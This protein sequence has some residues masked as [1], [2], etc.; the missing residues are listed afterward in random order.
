MHLCITIGGFPVHPNLNGQSKPLKA[1]RPH[2]A[3]VP[4]SVS[5]QT[6]MHG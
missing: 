2:V 3:G 6:C 5:V 4:G 1:S